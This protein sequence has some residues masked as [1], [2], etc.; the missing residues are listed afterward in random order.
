MIVNTLFLN[1]VPVD[2]NIMY[3]FLALKIDYLGFL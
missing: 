3:E 1:L 2:I